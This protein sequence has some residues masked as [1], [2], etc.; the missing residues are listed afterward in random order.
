MGNAS[1]SSGVRAAPIDAGYLVPPPAA[2]DHVAN[3]VAAPIWNYGARS[4]VLRAVTVGLV[5]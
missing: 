4:L 2:R 5:V 3:C 1:V